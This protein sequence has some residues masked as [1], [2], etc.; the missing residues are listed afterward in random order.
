MAVPTTLAMSRVECT[1]TV[2]YTRGHTV[3]P[4]ISEEKL[5]DLIKRKLESHSV[6]GIFDAQVRNKVQGKRDERECFSFVRLDGPSIEFMFQTEGPDTCFV[7]YLYGDKSNE[8]DTVEIFYILR[9]E[10]KTTVAV[11]TPASD[12]A[13]RLSDEAASRAGNGNALNN[14]AKVLYPTPPQVSDEDLIKTRLPEILAAGK[15]GQDLSNLIAKANEEKE[16]LIAE[17]DR[18]NGEIEGKKDEINALRKE[19]DEPGFKKLLS[20]YELLRTQLVKYGVVPDTA[21]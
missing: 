1:V 18:F 11:S 3:K 17:R 20:L 12:Q 4:Q 14:V 6:S 15:R 16:S 19:R 5:A 2:R 21:P 7:G 10:L 13:T 8:K 9:P